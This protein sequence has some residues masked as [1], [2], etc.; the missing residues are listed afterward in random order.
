M[1]EFAAARVGMPAARERTQSISGVINCRR[2]R[3]WYANRTCALRC[4]HVLLAP[5][6]LSVKQPGL[7][8]QAHTFRGQMS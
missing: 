8:Q 6:D 3:V 2:P 4:L 7:K 5:C 1:I